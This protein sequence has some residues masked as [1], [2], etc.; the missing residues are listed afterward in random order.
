MK[1][2]TR[3]FNGA[4]KKS[5]NVYRADNN[6]SDLALRRNELE[7]CVA[8]KFVNRAKRLAKELD[9][10]YQVTGVRPQSRQYD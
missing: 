2:F 4:F 7:G 1:P 3:I 10:E 8:M 9:L 5:G 6:G